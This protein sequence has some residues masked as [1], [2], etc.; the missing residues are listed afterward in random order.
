MSPRSVG[1][2]ETHR[3]HT[4]LKRRVSRDESD[5]GLPRPASKLLLTEEKMAAKMHNL[6][7]SN[8]HCYH[9]NGFQ[10]H[11]SGTNG[12][13]SNMSFSP[14]SNNTKLLFLCSDDDK[15]E[16]KE[17]D[18]NNM[19]SGDSTMF[20][21]APGIKEALANN[22]E[23]LPQSIIDHMS[24]PCLAVIPWKPQDDF[25][26]RISLNF[27]KTDDEKSAEKNTNYFESKVIGDTSHQQTVFI[28]R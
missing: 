25:I 10:S 12:M 1:C 14:L 24:K 2:I 11:V 5:D 20:V 4:G 8:D 27:N 22:N 13:V 3:K 21:L 18:N 15:D 28:E 19:E 17:D 23:L 6:R 7:I 16:H 9:V 26:T